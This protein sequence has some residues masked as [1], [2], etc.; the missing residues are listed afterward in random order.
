MSVSRKM[1][2]YFFPQNKNQVFQRRYIS[3]RRNM[4]TLKLL[5]VVETIA[6]VVVIAVVVV[7]MQQVKSPKAKS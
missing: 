2:G 3:R 5:F 4:S 6:I 7:N 1:R